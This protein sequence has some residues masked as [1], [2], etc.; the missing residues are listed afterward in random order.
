MHKKVP[1]QTIFNVDILGLFFHVCTKRQ[2]GH[3][4]SESL[5]C[6][7][8]KSTFSVNPTS[9]LSVRHEEQLH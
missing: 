7:V 1:N 2:N 4:G 8:K 9:G 3:G 6:P 5:E